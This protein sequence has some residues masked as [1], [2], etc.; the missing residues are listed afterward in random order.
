MAVNPVRAAGTLVLDEPVIEAGDATVRQRRGLPI[1]VNLDAGSRFP[2]LGTEPPGSCA[3]GSI[4]GFEG[5]IGLV[6]DLLAPLDAFG[7]A[8]ER[9]RDLRR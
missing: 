9:F 6:G 5:L 8:A 7:A 4:E 1:C 3:A 2:A